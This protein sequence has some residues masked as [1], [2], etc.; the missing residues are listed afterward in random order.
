MEFKKT[1]LKDIAQKAGVSLSTVHKALYDKPGIS[2]R[3][4]N[5]IVGIATSM[6]YKT[7]YVAS[8]LKRKP[9]RIAVVIP[10]PDLGPN[11]YFY[12]DIWKGLRQFKPQAAEFNVEFLEFGFSGS[13]EQLPKKLEEIYRSCADDI[14]GLITV[15]T[16]SPAVSYFIDRLIQK[17]TAVVLLCS[18]LPQSERLC[19]VRAQDAMAGGLAAE[20]LHRFTAGQ[21]KIA[22]AA[23]DPLNPSHYLNVDGFQTYLSKYAPQM[24]IIRI[25]ND[26]APQ[27][28]YQEIKQ[29]LEQD[30]EITGLY[31]C[32]ARNTLPL[33]RAARDTPSNRKPHIIG[34]DLFREN[35]EFLLQNTL[36]AIIYKNPIKMAFLACQ[37]IFNYLVK[38]EFP[39]KENVYVFPT[40]V[41]KSN[42]SHYTNELSFLQNE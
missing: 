41:L 22:I 42:L 31:S 6:G 7:N 3:V 17:N 13:I 23:G 15:A 25:Y 5:E 33:C 4:K 2:E 35:E 36:Q 1:T 32:N 18:D 11:R 27:Q 37:T 12:Q 30:E 8:S 24:E 34:S 14:A 21:G 40:I 19:C 38:N 26:N 28:L 9:I 16:E 39:R 20:L 10:L 29:L